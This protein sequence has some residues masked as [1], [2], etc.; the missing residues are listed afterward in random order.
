MIRRREESTRNRGWWILILC[1]AISLGA[2]F[3]TY[4]ALQQQTAHDIK[5]TSE[6]YSERTGNALNSIFRK[7]DVLA[8]VVELHNGAID[9]DTF[10]Q[11]AQIVYQPNSGIRGI[12]YMPGAVVAYS[13]PVE[14]NEAVMGKNFFDIPERAADVWLAINTKSIALSGPYNLIQGGLGVVARNPVFL[15]DA[16]GNEYFWGFSTIVIDLPDALSSVALERLPEAG[17]DYQLFSVNE[18]GERLV[19]EGNENL[20]VSTATCGAIEVPHHE[21]TLAIAPLNPLINLQISLGILFAGLLI[22]TLVWRLYRLMAREREAIRAK[23]R[24]FSSISHDMRTP[25]NAVIGFSTLAERPGV[26]AAEKDDYLQKIRNSGQLLLNLVN[27]TLTLSKGSNGKIKLNPQPISTEEISETIEEPIRELAVQNGVELTIDRTDCKR[28]IILADRLSV[29]KIFLNLLNNAIKFTP[30]GG[31]VRESITCKIADADHAEYLITVADDGIGISEEFLPRIFEPFSQEQKKGYEG[32]GTG[33]GLAIVKQLVDL[34]N[35]TI[36]VKSREGVGTTFTVRLRFA[37]ATETPTAPIA[38]SEGSPP[39]C[40]L[41]NLHVLMCEDNAINCEIATKLL[42]QEG[43][44]VDAATNGEEG[45]ERFAQ[46][47]VGSYDCILMDIRMPR[48]DGLAAT[49]ALRALDR[50]DA[51]TVPIIA[52][53]ADA[54]AEDV[55]K[56]LDAGMNAHV[57][58]PIDPDALFKALRMALAANR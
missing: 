14:G 48:M 38:A 11:I 29:E 56:C 25:L 20:D 12:Q 46:S 35:G 51:K 15:T 21:W 7:T 36:S 30:T 2:A 6:L 24:F 3:F 17:Y 33:L 5:R 47:P 50:S 8:A 40:S 4:Q 22:S 18:N 58:K 42:E 31:H 39:S 44:I 37:L 26:S 54:F 27:D 16:N 43:M 28:R 32:M 55:R 57:A 13:Y 49:R 9:E 34:M 23:D 53:T 41:A 1:I 52:M 10:N 19:I 45:I